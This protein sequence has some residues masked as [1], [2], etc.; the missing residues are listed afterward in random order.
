MM[1]HNLYQENIKSKALK[2]RKF[3]DRSLKINAITM[4]V[5]DSKTNSLILNLTSK[6]GSKT[7][8]VN[9]RN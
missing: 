7:R 4:N 5:I 1:K 2:K 8:D 6:H 3:V 9:S